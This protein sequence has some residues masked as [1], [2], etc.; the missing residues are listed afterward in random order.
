M[1]EVK[2]NTHPGWVNMGVHVQ[3]LLGQGCQRL[4]A[5]DGDH[6]GEDI[7][8]EGEADDVLSTPRH[9]VPLQGMPTIRSL[10]TLSLC[11]AVKIWEEEGRRQR[12]G[13]YG[14]RRGKGMWG[15]GRGVGQG[16]GGVEE[17]IDCGDW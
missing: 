7:L 15:K 8:V 4:H 12:W 13:D 11:T 1:A 17:G 16:G 10:G 6:I 5:I 2:E 9:T 3:A 14:G